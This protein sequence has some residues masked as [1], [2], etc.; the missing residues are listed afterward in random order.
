MFVYALKEAFSTM[1]RAKLTSFA[2]TITVTVC[3]FLLGLFM[4]AYVNADGIVAKIRARVQIE[5]FLSDQVDQKGA[6]ALADSIRSFPTV[7]T[8]SYVSLLLIYLLSIHSVECIT[9]LKKMLLKPEKNI[10]TIC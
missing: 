1:Q 6:L 2:A 10:F 4:M 9:P 5:A 7:K 8:V 3:L